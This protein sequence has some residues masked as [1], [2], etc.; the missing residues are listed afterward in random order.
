MQGF[1]QRSAMSA[2]RL[3]F[4][5]HDTIG[6]LL[7]GPVAVRPDPAPYPSHPSTFVFF[8]ALDSLFAPASLEHRRRFVNERNTAVLVFGL[9][10][11]ELGKLL[12][13]LAG[14]RRP[15]KVRRPIEL[16]THA[17]T[18]RGYLLVSALRSS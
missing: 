8:P 9:T 2:A 12:R 3:W 6:T 17:F 14:Q 18:L 11:P 15:M 5:L 7:L 13:L 4:A 10:K 16:H 1:A